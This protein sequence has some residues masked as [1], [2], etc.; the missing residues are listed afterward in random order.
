MSKTEW[1]LVGNQGEKNDATELEAVDEKGNKSEIL[2]SNMDNMDELI[3]G[4][5]DVESRPS[6]SK[7]KLMKD[8]ILPD[9][10]EVVKGLFL[11]GH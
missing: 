7:R 3:V 5:M 4:E 10:T 9:A 2:S 8:H 1:T 6:S 11:A